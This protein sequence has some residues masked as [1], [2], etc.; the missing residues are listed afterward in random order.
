VSTLTGCRSTITIQKYHQWSCPPGEEPALPERKAIETD[1]FE[2]L[3]N[4]GEAFGGGDIEVKEVE[5]NG[6]SKR[7]VLEGNGES[8]DSAALAKHLSD[9]LKDRNSDTES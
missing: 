5:E 2:A 3:L 6:S 9:A 1:L 4:L 7:V 8:F